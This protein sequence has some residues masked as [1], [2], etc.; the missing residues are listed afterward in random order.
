MFN[1]E[2]LFGKSTRGKRLKSDDRIPGDLPFVTAGESNEGVSAFIGNNVTVFSG[3]TTTIDM[4][5]SAKYRNYKYGADDHV[6]VV[7]TEKLSRH[8]AIFITSAIHKSSYTGMFDYGRNFYAK[9]ADQL[10]IYLPSKNQQPDY[11]FME[12]YIAELEAERIAELEA[13][14]IAEL[15]AYLT[16][17]GLKDYNLT[18]EEQQALDEFNDTN[19]S[20]GVLNISD[21]FN[22]IEQGRRLKKDDQIKGDI[23]FVMAGVTNSGVVNFISNPV[24][25]FPRNSITADIFGN[26]FY[27]NYDFG[28][29]DDT[30]VYWS[31]NNNYSKENMLFFAASMGC[32][33]KGKYD[34]GKKLRS[35]QSK[36]KTMNVI[37]KNNMPDYSFMEILISAIQKLVIKDV[38]Q[39]ADRKI[40]L[41]RQVVKSGEEKV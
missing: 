10:N 23:P 18:I 21:I 13:E 25:S 33:L 3:N 39:Y 6:A 11:E 17:T 7:H 26:V 32:L 16:A 20:W 5:G 19:V 1:V 35:S 31:D 15:E 12:N 38:V 29:G 30:G 40:A 22:K 41:H 8:A 2:K 34:F 14:R 27:R 4:F 24:S 36:N 37:I 28:A 9:D